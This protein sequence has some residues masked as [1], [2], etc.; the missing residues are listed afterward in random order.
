ML[1]LLGRQVERDHIAPTRLLLGRH[2]V[3]LT[4]MLEVDVD[5]P[6]GELLGEQFGPFERLCSAL[7]YYLIGGFGTMVS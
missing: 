3:L 6:I 1:G 2:L 5:P 7:P 4:S